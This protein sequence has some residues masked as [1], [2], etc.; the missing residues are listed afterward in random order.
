MNVS[1]T[2]S[3]DM[4]TGRDTVVTH[5]RARLYDPVLMRFNLYVKRRSIFYLLTNQTEKAEH[6]TCIY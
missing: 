2:T 3:H 1:A 4:G 6:E 5:T